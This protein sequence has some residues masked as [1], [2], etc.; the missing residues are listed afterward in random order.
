MKMLVLGILASVAFSTSAFAAC[1]NGEAKTIREYADIGNHSR[2]VNVTYICVNGRFY[3]HGNAPKY[4]AACASGTTKLIGETV[5]VGNHTKIVPTTYVCVA[6]V[7]R[8]NGVVPS[9]KGCKEGATGFTTI[10]IGNDRIKTV[11]V[12]CVGGKYVQN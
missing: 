8:R 10:D 6:G 2:E 11:A 7:W 9:Y 5:D 1:S 12:T 4:P 3:K